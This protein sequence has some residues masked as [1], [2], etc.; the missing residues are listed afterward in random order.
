VED[1]PRGQEQGVA[2]VVHGDYLVPEDRIRH[3]ASPIHPK[4]GGVEGAQVDQEVRGLPEEEGQGPRGPLPLPPPLFLKTVK[5][6]VEGLSFSL[7]KEGRSLEVLFLPL[8]P[9]RW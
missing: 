8:F 5:R 3:P 7:K 2:G 9:S 4:A 6:D 1:F